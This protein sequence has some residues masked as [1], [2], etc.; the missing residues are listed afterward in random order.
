[1][2]HPTTAFGL[3]LDESV[4]TDSG[5]RYG[6][7]IIKLEVTDRSYDD[8]LR[9]FAPCRL[10]KGNHVYRAWII[11]DE[12]TFDVVKERLSQDDLMCEACSMVKRGDIVKLSRELEKQR[13]LRQTLVTTLTGPRD[14]KPELRAQG[15]VRLSHPRAAGYND[16][17]RDGF[18]FVPDWLQIKTAGN[19]RALTML[20]KMLKV[21]VTNRDGM[22]GFDLT[23]TLARIRNDGWV[24]ETTAEYGR[25]QRHE[26]VMQAVASTPVG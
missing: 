7:Y 15:H 13:I 2:T 11:G 3:T 18:F 1:M 8:I 24:T 21:D 14:T 10:C 5:F 16:E 17:M 4:T 22:F 25:L 26:A 19:I 23:T 20:S 9:V 6:D 12:P